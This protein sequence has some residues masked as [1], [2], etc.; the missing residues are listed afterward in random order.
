MLSNFWWIKESFLK[1]KELISENSIK[2]NWKKFKYSVQQIC[3]KKSS[4]PRIS[5]CVYSQL[6]FWFKL[7]QLQ[8]MYYRKLFILYSGKW[9][10]CIVQYL[11]CSNY[12]SFS[13]WNRDQI[14]IKLGTKY[15]VYSKLA[16]FTSDKDVYVNRLESVFFDM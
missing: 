9:K 4:Y 14:G 16:S 7:C 3:C 12:V 13:Q 11:N 2:C 6:I 8:V 1:F 5:Y 15:V 10:L